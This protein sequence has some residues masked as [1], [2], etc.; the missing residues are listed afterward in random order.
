MNYMKM[1]M[2]NLNDWIRKLSQTKPYRIMVKNGLGSY[3]ILFLYGEYHYTDKLYAKDMEDELKCQKK[4]LEMCS[5][6][7]HNFKL[8]IF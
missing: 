3:E 6:F 4:V 7:E 1:S 8:K 2:T 5:T